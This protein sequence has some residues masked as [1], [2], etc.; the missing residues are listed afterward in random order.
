MSSDYAIPLNDL[1]D[2]LNPLASMNGVSDIIEYQSPDADVSVLLA[3]GATSQQVRVFYL[4]NLREDWEWVSHTDDGIGFVLL[5][6][7][8]D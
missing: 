3:D 7:R 6:R 4:K 2:E 5:K 1:P 8:G